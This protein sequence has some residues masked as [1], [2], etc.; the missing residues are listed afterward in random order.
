[1]IWKLLII[2]Q[3]KHYIADY[4]LQGKYMLGK[5]RDKGWIAPLAAHCLV[6]WFFTYFIAQAYC[7]T[8]NAIGLATLDFTIHFIMDRI[9]ASPKLLGRYKGLS[10]NEYPSATDEQKRSN[11]LFWWALGLDQL[12]HHCTDLLIVY[13]IISF[14]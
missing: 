2:I 8:T 12:V 6:H 4:L 9:K 13:L 7:G 11:T 10:A 14:S 1:M 3:F 5:F